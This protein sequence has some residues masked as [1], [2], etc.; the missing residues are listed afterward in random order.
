MS[1][2]FIFIIGCIFVCVNLSVRN[3]CNIQDPTVIL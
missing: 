1:V 2:F 3:V